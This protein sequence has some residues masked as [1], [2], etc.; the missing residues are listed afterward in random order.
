LTLQSHPLSLRLTILQNLESSVPL[1]ST[2]G[3]VGSVPA[4]DLGPLRASLPLFLAAAL[5]LLVS[6][7]ACAGTRGGPIPYNTTNF[8]APDQASPTQP[9]EEDYKIS[10]LD[11]LHIAVFQVPDLTGDFQV[12]LAGTIEMPLV[13][14]VHAVGL[15]TA[16]LD[17]KL[18]EM[19]GQKYLQHPDVSVDVKSSTSSNITV[20]GSVKQAGQF[21]VTSRLTLL[22]AIALAHG[23]DENANPHRIAIF[24]QIKGQRMAAAFDLT[25][26]RRGEAEDPPVYRGDIIVVDGSKVKS[27]W[28]NILQTLPLLAIFRPFGI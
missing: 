12:Q 7:A 25:S 2:S 10:P 20:D 22:Q 21:A 17:Q 5:A 13:G 23:T 19:L 9:L 15:T 6:L 4:F 16:Q 14:S 24:R 18:T 11:T 28:Q 3:E 8:G 27:A 1:P 26:I